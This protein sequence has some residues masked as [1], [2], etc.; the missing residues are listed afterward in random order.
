MQLGVTTG[1]MIGGFRVVS[2]I[3]EGAMGAVYLAKDPEGRRVA[4][5]LLVPDLA[6]DERF[7]QRFLRESRLAARLDHPHVVHT[8]AFGEDDGVLYLAMDYVDGADLRELLRR[9]GKLEPEQ[10]LALLGHVADGLDAAHAVGLVHRDV[11]PANILVTS[12]EGRE[13]AYVCDFGLARHVTS[14]R[15]LTGERALVGTIDY[16]PPE[17]I[18]GGSV[19]ARADVYS[20]ACVLFECLAGVRPFDRESELSVIFAH[21]NAPPPLL[22]D[23]RPNLPEAFD[24]VFATALAKSPEHRYATCRELVEACRSAL[25]G[26]VVASRRVRRRRLAVALAAVAGVVTVVGVVLGVRGGSELVHRSPRAHALALTPNGL[27]AIDARTHRVVAGTGFGNVVWDVAFAGGSAWALLGDEHRIARIDLVHR[28]VEKVFGLA[29]GHGARTAA[30]GGSVW[31]QE[32]NGPGV[33]AI[34]AATG[35]V[36][37]R[38]TVGGEAGG[39]IAYGSGSLWLARGGDVVRV[40]PKSGRVVRRFPVGGTATWVVFADGA[41]YAASS[42]NGGLTKIDPV[43]NTVAATQKLHGWISDLAAGGGFVWAAVIPDGV[44]FKLSADD[45]SVQGSAASGPDPE[46]ISFGGGRLWIAS[47]DLKTIS[48]LEP[49][50]GKR[51]ALSTDGAPLLAA[52]HRGLVWTSAAPVPKPLPPITGQELRI[53]MPNNLIGADPSTSR[54]PLEEQLVYATCANLLGYPDSD[55]PQGEQLRPEL[56]AAMPAISH[57][58]RTYAFQIRPSLRFSP[59]SPNRPASLRQPANAVPETVTAETFRH[60]IERALSPEL[61]ANGPGAPFASDIVGVAL[62]RARKAAHIRGIV[63]RGD[64]LSIRLVRPAGDFLTRISMPYFCPVPT[65][66]PVVPGGLTG[67]IP[68]L[69]P[70][71][72]AQLEDNRTVLLRNPNYAGRRPRKVERIVYALGVPTPTAVAQ[73]ATGD[74]DYLPAD[75]DQ[76]SMLAPEGTIDRRYGPGSAAAR[77]GQQR[78]F[79]EPQPGVDEIVFNTQRPLF[80]DL[81]LRRA[82]NYALDRPALAAVWGERATDGYIPPAVPAFRAPHVYPTSGP[83]LRSARRLAGTK[84]RRAVL[85]FCGDPANRRIADIVRLDLSRIGIDVSIVESSGCL[86]GSDPR[87]AQADLLLGGF[88]SEERDPAPFIQQALAQGAYGIPPGPGPWREQSFRRRLQRA[89]ELA[90]TARVAAYR[91]LQEELLRAAPFAAYGSSVQP[92]YFSASVGCKVVQSAYHFVDLG[93]LC[94]R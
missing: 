21:L 51:A 93:A 19:D 7:R 56:A 62:Y 65:R 70:Y 61:G 32:S 83:D 20:L 24:A 58:G 71:Y 6:R 55:T 88:F 8:L 4:L 18:E 78:Y 36:S 26:R 46:R 49:D 63:A 5:K 57:D 37:H 84:R 44:V 77:R 48:L 23:V 91:K 12:V 22:T 38:F 72:V 27:D 87:A 13:H 14:V 34:D 45:L 67:A 73:I 92:D 75:F 90:G 43:D 3:G 50:S 74:I 35:K 68:S 33:I 64:S 76:H 80:R 59:P 1:T 89:G 66:E 25:H 41:V 53:S 69:G 9:E 10:A 94:T 47:R 15:S 82:V 30:G 54:G 29:E 16:V 31:V 81:R 85:Y 40:D 42:G 17:Q 60:T 86:H 52:Y 11:K 28:R 79:L 39:G 2:M